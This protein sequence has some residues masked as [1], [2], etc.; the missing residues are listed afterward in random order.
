MRLGD[1]NIPDSI[2]ITGSNDDCIRLKYFRRCLISKVALEKLCSVGYR[3]LWIYFIFIRFIHLSYPLLILYIWIHLSMKY[4]PN[5]SFNTIFVMWN[6]NFK[7]I[8]INL[9]TGFPILFFFNFFK[10]YK[11]EFNFDV[12]IHPM[13]YV[14]EKIPK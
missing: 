8:Y 3:L 14:N 6:H 13:R 11:S 4:Y 7:I 2:T 5:I 9:S 1:R 10:F 12:F